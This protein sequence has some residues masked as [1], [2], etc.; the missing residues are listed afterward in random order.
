MEDGLLF[1]LGMCTGSLMMLFAILR[2]IAGMHSRLE[3]IQGRR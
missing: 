3:Q 1:L 2:A